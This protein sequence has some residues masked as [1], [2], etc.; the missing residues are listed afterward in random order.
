MAD[1]TWPAAKDR[2]LIGQR[3]SR[4][5]GP[6]KTTGRAK[7]TYDLKL[8][9]MLYAKVLRCPHAHARVKRLDLAAAQSMPG[10]KAVRIIQGLGAEIQWAQDEIAAVAATSE[11]I[12]E[13]ALRA[14][15]VEYEVLPHFVSEERLADA[16]VRA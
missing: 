12:A 2:R 16:G 9:G 4:L 7:Y 3:I 11:G 14:I 15:R 1:P 8:P 13:D 5:D 10:V 6:A